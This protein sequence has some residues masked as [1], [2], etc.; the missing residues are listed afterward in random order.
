MQKCIVWSEHLTQSTYSHSSS[1][2]ISSSSLL[3]LL[4][5][6]WLCLVAKVVAKV[7]KARVERE[8]EANL[9]ILQVGMVEME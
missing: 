8:R 7:V 2:R 3:V 9:A 6:P 1:T 5:L 4:E